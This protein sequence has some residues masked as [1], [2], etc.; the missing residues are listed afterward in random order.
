M[1][2][3]G[4]WGLL[5]LHIPGSVGVEGVGLVV[6]GMTTSGSWPA[7]PGTGEGEGVAGRGIGADGVAGGGVTTGEGDRGGTGG[8]AGWGIPGGVGVG[9]VEVTAAGW[10][11]VLTAALFLGALGS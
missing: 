6:G 4:N 10:V 5:P 2:G 11:G 1:A 9:S 8:E 7:V 3:L